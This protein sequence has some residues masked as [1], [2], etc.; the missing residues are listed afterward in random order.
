MLLRWT[1]QGGFTGHSDSPFSP[2]RNPGP[3]PIGG[4]VLTK[5]LPFFQLPG[6]SISIIEG[7]YVRPPPGYRR[8]SG[9]PAWPGPCPHRAY[10]LAV[11][12]FTGFQYKNKDRNTQQ[13]E[14][15]RGRGQWT[16]AALTYLCKIQI[17]RFF[18]KMI[19]HH[20]YC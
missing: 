6:H 20:L 16:V 8:D 4:M 2:C 12:L 13:Q 11:I 1:L 10:I 14:L 18:K 15:Y 7:L 5:L 3:G 17:T 9:G 19:K